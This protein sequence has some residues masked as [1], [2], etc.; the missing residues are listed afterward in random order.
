MSPKC[1]TIDLAGPRHSGFVLFLVLFLVLR[2]G[3][4]LVLLLVLFLRF[5]I[6]IELLLRHS[7]DA[8]VHNPEHNPE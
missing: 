5:G 1:A 3:F 4:V 2:I 7:Q 6:G 8:P